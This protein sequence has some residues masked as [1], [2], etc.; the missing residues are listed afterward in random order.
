MPV[1]KPRL[2]KCWSPGGDR[3]GPGPSIYL[4]RMEGLLP[5]DGGNGELVVRLPSA[6]KR[7]D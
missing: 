4:P 6:D 7:P 5:A 3:L 1:F 2:Q